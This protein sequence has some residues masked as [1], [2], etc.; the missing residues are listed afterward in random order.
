MKKKIKNKYIFFLILVLI[1]II[2]HNKIHYDL[3]K[4]VNSTYESRINK[5][6]GYCDQYGYLFIK[7]SLIDTNNKKKI[8]IYNANDLAGIKWKFSEYENLKYLNNLN[9]NLEIYDY[10]FLISYPD[11]NE[12]KISENKIT[13]NKIIFTVKNKFNNCYFLEKL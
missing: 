4:I 2:Y 10:L 3:Y 12:L 13:L 7:K 9:L 11:N 5:S 6:Y 8:A 1:I